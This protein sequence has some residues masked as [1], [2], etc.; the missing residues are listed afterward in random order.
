MVAFRKEPRETGLASVARPYPATII[1]KERGGNQVGKISPPY[2]N[3]RGPDS[4]KWSVRIMIK[5]ASTKND[6][7]D[8]YWV[9]FKIKHPSEP[10]ARVW[11][12][13]R[14]AAITTKYDLY[15]MEG[16]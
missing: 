5:K 12:K 1:L 15:E 11:L 4:N 8:F 6:P 2:W 3:D 14:W 13:E 10:E 9:T 7:A 16:D